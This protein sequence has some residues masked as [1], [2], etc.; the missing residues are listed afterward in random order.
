MEALITANTT[1]N[2]NISAKLICRRGRDRREPPAAPCDDGSATRLDAATWLCNSFMIDRPVR[3][4][5]VDRPAASAADATTPR[6]PARRCRDA[7][8]G[9]LHPTIHTA[10]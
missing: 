8:T 7:A 3:A 9:T 2:N 6:S 1:I 4:T 10:G 5:P